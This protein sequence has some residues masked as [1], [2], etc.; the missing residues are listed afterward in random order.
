MGGSPHT[1]HGGGS[2]G[3][4]MHVGRVHRYEHLQMAH[5]NK[6]L[7][8]RLELGGHMYTLGKSL[9]PAGKGLVF[10][11]TSAEEENAAVLIFAGYHTDNLFHPLNGVD[12]A[13]VGGKGGDAYPGT[14]LGPLAD[15]LGKTFQGASSGWEE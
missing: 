9:A 13:L 14:R 15:G 5:Q 1:H 7:V 2:E 12:L 8:E 10:L 4:Q 3:C 6:F 11:L